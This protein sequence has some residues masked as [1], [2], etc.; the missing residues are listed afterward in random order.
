[1]VTDIIVEPYCLGYN[2]CSEYMFANV[3]YTTGYSHIQINICI[4][5][6]CRIQDIC[7]FIVAYS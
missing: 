5:I 2:T 4:C 1:M 3:L 6:A 7:K